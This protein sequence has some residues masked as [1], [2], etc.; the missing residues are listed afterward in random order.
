MIEGELALAK[1]KE[2]VMSY[3]K[4]MVHVVWSTKNRELLIIPQIKNDLLNHIK[5]NSIAKNIFIDSM[6]CVADHVHLLISLGSDQS[7]SK[8]VQLIKGES[9][10]WLNEQHMLKGKFG[11]QDDYFATSVSESMLDT[12]REYI[13]NQEEHHKKKTFADEYNDFLNKFGFSQAHH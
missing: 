11:W 13:H 5:E 6:N 2:G 4:M 8:I 10:H 1:Q 9:S 3:I 12:V 7:I